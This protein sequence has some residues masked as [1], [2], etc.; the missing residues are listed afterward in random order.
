MSLI[1][2]GNTQLLDYLYDH[3]MYCRASSMDYVL[4]I[5]N[6]RLFLGPRYE[7]RIGYG[8]DIVSKCEDIIV[9]L[10]EEL[11]QDNRDK[12][13]AIRQLVEG[14]YAQLVRYFLPSSYTLCSSTLEYLVRKNK[15][16]D[17]EYLLNSSNKSWVIDHIY[18]NFLNDYCICFSLKN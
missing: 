16:E 9:S 5:R 13:I 12:T 17:L 14:G 1:A 15:F 18:Y 10:I 7:N 3:G 8:D 2:A 4:E 11:N 6:G